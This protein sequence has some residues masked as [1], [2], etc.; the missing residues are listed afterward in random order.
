MAAPTAT[1][2]YKYQSGFGNE[3]HTEALPG[4]VPHG[5][6]APQ[7]VPYNLYAEQLSGSAFTAP[8][9]H[10]HRSW[11][12]RIRPSV[13]HTP[14]KRHDSKSTIVKSFAVTDD[15][16]SCE[17]TPNQLRWSPFEIP[18]EKE[19][20]DFTEGLHAVCGA[21]DPSMKNG[22]AIYV[23][24]AN[25]SMVDTAMY[26]SDGEFLI[27]PQQ[28]RLDVQTEM[29]YLMVE[30]S[31]ILVIPRGVRFSVRIPDGPSRGYILEI[32]DRRFELPDLG[33]IGA[34]GLANPRDFL[35]PTAA[36]EDI[37]DRTFRIVNKYQGRFFVATQEHS[38]FDV[39]GWHGNYAPYKYDL[40]LF[41]TINTV[42]YDHPDPSIFTVLTAKTANPGVAL[43]DFVIFPPRWMV[44]EHTFRP[45]YFHRNCMSEF[46]GLINGSYDAKAEGFLPGGAS[47]H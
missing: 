47:L 11:L 38:P 3:F 21:G 27:V 41:N 22:L 1:G 46:M 43:A 7:K 32:F 18:G 35:Y 24:L 4:A 12:Y 40:R 31:E 15:N 23:Y 42:S 37:Q 29:G 6:N 16:D 20:V 10:N 17:S 13:C 25:T 2:T 8:R 28:G 30:P 34:N 45:P 5:Q 14:F 33:P 39:V 26:N 36:Y 19:K 44:A 9:T